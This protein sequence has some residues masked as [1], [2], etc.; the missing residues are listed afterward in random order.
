MAHKEEIQ[1]QIMKR[2]RPAFV[3]LS[4]TRVTEEIEDNELNMPGY[5]MVRG[6]IKVKSTFIL[7]LALPGNNDVDIQKQHFSS[8]PIKRNQATSD[9]VNKEAIQLDPFVQSI[10]HCKNECGENKIYDSQKCKKRI[11]SEP[12]PAQP[13]E[14]W[15]KRNN[16]A[17]AYITLSVE[18]NQLINFTHFENAF[19]IWQALSKKYER[20]T[21][22]SRLYLRRKLYSIHYRGKPMS[23]HI[24]AI[25]EVVGLLRGSGKP[26]E[27]EEIVAVLLV[28]LPETYSGLVTAL[29]GRNEADLTIEYVTGKMLDEYQ[30]RT[31]SGESS[32]KKSEV[33]L[34]SAVINKGSNSDRS[35]L[36]KTNQ[37]TSKRI[38]GS[39]RN[40]SYSR[41]IGTR[42]KKNQQ[43]QQRSVFKVVILR[44]LYVRRLKQPLQEYVRL[45]KSKTEVPGVVKEYITEMSVRFGRKP[46]ALRT[47]NGKEYISSELTDFLK[48]EGIQHQLTVVYTP[49][50]NGV[51]E[52]KNR[53]LTESAKCMLLDAHLDN[54]FWGEAV[55][56]AAYLQNRMTS[57]S[58]DETP[59]E[60]FIGEKPDISHI[61]VFG[62][63]V[64]SMVPKQKRRKWDDKAEG[65]LVGYDGN[66]KE[67]EDKQS[68]HYQ[69]LRKE[70]A[71]SSVA[72]PSR[73]IEYEMPEQNEINEDSGSEERSEEEISDE[74]YETS[75]D[76]M[77]EIW[78]RRVSQRT[79]KGVPP[80]RL[81]YKVQTNSVQEPE[82]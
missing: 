9:L 37:A 50:Q 59:V 13:D 56:T 67:H 55:L 22:G 2:M 35:S 47:D 78:Q 43:R 52:R 38:V 45:L 81:T 24:D 42:N 34:Q 53:S 15:K 4:E 5:N 25:M 12:K 26:L 65:V 44:S 28:S 36:N 30:R 19:D 21:F 71:S 41:R 39:T 1:H 10:C 61:R 57:R 69:V 6:H 32:E 66:I 63:K 60:L 70:G 33:A 80:P 73:T 7:L 31:E 29:E 40:H 27:D 54:R 14:V 46:I 68:G 76:A 64:C 77:P 20:S 79:N 48:K 17:M 3:A 51:A 23:S 11:E 75:D 58:I 74:S 82:S 62:S 8:I 72:E 16:K 49:Q 18:D